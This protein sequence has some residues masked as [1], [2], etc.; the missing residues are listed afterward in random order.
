V[1]TLIPSFTAA[2]FVEQLFMTVTYII[3][4]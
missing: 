4:R 2:S 3:R 1:T